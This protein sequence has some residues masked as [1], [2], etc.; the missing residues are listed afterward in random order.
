MEENKNENIL[1]GHF[2]H[3]ITY[4]GRT[5]NHNRIY[6]PS[7]FDEIKN[8]FIMGVD[9]ALGNNS[10]YTVFSKVNN[11]YKYE[12]IIADSYA[13]EIMKL[14]ENAKNKPIKIGFN[15]DDVV[16][17]TS[18]R[19][20]WF[21]I[22]FYLKKYGVEPN[23]NYEDLDLS[24]IK[25]TL[26]LSNETIELDNDSVDEDG[27]ID[28]TKIS[29]DN[30]NDGLSEY[31]TFIEENYL[32][33][34]GNS[35]EVYK[36]VSNDLNNLFELMNENN[37][38]PIIIQRES[39]IIRNATLFFLSDKGIGMDQ[40]NFI[41]TYEGAFEHCDYLVAANPNFLNI[42]PNKTIK[43]NTHYNK[44]IKVKYELDKIKEMFELVLNIN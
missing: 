39:G 24:D 33:I 28:L 41:K 9:P 16:R 40:I 1:Y 22:K 38:K 14:Y 13:E 3:P 43:I 30:Y 6:D 5:N 23:L 32:D 17:A 26:G 18:E 21:Y 29:N 12:T 35:K 7:I 2:D 8:K 25:K 27:I 20:Y 31:E 15:L 11:L 37:I 36:G 4:S 10:D 34:F 42:N 19:I 44:H